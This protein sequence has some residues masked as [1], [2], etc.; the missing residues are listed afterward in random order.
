MY[1]D[2]QQLGTPLAL[3]CPE[4]VCR[5]VIRVRIKRKPPVSQVDGVPLDRFVVGQEYDL[6]NIIAG[7]LLAEQWAE[8]LP[9]DSGSSSLDGSQLYDIAVPRP[10]DPSNLIRE[11]F[12]PSLDG[13]AQAADRARREARPQPGRR[14]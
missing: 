12:P 1:F 5:R 8:P 7:L 11:R 3:F 10:R 2:Q 6:G 13:I 4:E 14:R 9:L